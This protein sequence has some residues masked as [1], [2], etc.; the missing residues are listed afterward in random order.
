MP[1]TW[2][3]CQCLFTVL[4]EATT[5]FSSYQ[6]SA[7]SF[8]KW[9]SL[10]RNLLCFISNYNFCLLTHVILWWL[11]TKYDEGFSTKCILRFW[12]SYAEVRCPS[13][14]YLIIFDTCFISHYS[15]RNDHS[16]QV[17]YYVIIGIYVF[18]VFRR[19]MFCGPIT[20]CAPL[21]LEPMGGAC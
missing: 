13:L 20:I 1:L 10:E 6:L 3:A 14:S 18:E 11:K 16:N 9:L 12:R 7:D 4:W 2:D 8:V 19:K 17:L 21:M 15:V 5:N